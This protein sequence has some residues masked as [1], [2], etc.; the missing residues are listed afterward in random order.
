MLR[1]IIVH[2]SL[3]VLASIRLD[4]HSAVLWRHFRLGK[5]ASDLGYCFFPIH[6]KWFYVILLV[7]GLILT[8]TIQG[9]VG[10]TPEAIWNSCLNKEQTRCEKLQHPWNQS[11]MKTKGFTSGARKN[12]N[13]SK[14]CLPN[15]P[16]HRHSK[17]HT[18]APHLRV[19]S[20]FSWRHW[21]YGLFKQRRQQQQQQ[22]PQ[23]HK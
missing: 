11:T 2:S 20:N 18:K 10:G 21:Q 1:Q 4:Q 8:F 6:E 12:H 7:G 15:S 14:R 22:Q 9:Q 19:T 23:A 5:G 13:S 16:F 3:R 17:S